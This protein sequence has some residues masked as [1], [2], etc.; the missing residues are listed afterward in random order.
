MTAFQISSPD[1]ARVQAIFLAL[2]RTGADLTPLMQQTAAIMQG[3]TEDAFERERSPGGQPWQPLAPATVRAYVTKGR[4]AAGGRRT[5]RRRR[6]AHPILQVTGRLASSVTT[7]VTK[8]SA[9]IGTKDLRAATHQFGRGAIP[10][11]E[12]IGLG[13]DH[14][15]QIESA[16]GDFLAATLTRPR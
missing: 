7:R 16:A 1:L 13:F 12:F 4:K 6:G 8:T 9:E 14:V 15:S 5:G 11:R 3:A 2:G 10:A